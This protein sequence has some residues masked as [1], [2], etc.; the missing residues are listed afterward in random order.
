MR[1]AKPALLLATFALTACSGTVKGTGTS[2]DGGTSS[3]TPAPSP[4]DPLFTTPASV[5]VTNDALDGVW[6]GTMA[7]SG[8]DVRLVITPSAVTIAVRCNSGGTAPV[9]TIG[10]TVNAV[11]SSTSI[12]TLESKSVV[13]TANCKIVVHPQSYGRCSTG[14]AGTMCFDLIGTDLDFGPNELFTGDPYGPGHAFT[15]MSDGT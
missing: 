14:S 12:R 11:T 3:A 6:A 13:G 7:I 2:P 8:D 15:K 9:V 10:T 4:Y 1:L 5:T